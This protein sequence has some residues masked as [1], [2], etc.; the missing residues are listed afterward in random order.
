[1]TL[2]SRFRRILLCPNAFKGSL[3]ASEAARAMAE[4]VARVG[5]F[6]TVCLPLADGGDG[7][8]ETLVEATGGTLHSAVGAGSAWPTGHG[9]LGDGWE[10]RRAIPP[11]SRWRRRPG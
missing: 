9:G 2:T 8:L 3:T 7:T 1:M 10:G 4:G 6:E 5:A 11:S